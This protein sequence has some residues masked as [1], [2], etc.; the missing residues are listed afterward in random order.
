MRVRD[1]LDIS[2][3]PRLFSFS[4]YYV[5]FVYFVCLCGEGGGHCGYT[6]VRGQL[7]QLAAILELS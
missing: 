2:L 3:A 6:E 7:T 4:L 5:V 1:K